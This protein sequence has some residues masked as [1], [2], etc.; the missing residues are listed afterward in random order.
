[1]VFYLL[2]IAFTVVHLFMFLYSLSYF[3]YYYS[4]PI[5]DIHCR[6][7]GLIHTNL[8]G[9]TSIALTISHATRWSAKGLTCIGSMIPLRHLPHG[10]IFSILAIS[11]LLPLHLILH[12]NR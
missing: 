8:L 10:C 5:S 11:G 2:A 4:E 7:F 1:M 12:C 3:L 9:S 6:Y